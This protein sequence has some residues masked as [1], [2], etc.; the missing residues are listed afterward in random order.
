MSSQLRSRPMLS[1]C[2]CCGPQAQ[3]HALPRSVKTKRGKEAAEEAVASRGEEM[4][5]AEGVAAGPLVA[6]GVGAVAVEEEEA[7]EEA[8]VVA[9]IRVH[10]RSTR[11]H[12]HSA[13][14]NLT[15][16]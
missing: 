4:A 5:I 12:Q 15:K 16:A 1:T 6:V 7:A 14:C 11:G 3:H 10:T 9:T 2:R 8:A 13:L